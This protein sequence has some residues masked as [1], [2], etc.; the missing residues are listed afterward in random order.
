MRRD[1]L[2]NTRHI[3]AV[4]TR[5]RRLG[6]AA[7]ESSLQLIDF[8]V[9]RWT[10]PQQAA[11]RIARLLRTTYTRVVVLRTIAPNSGRN[12][13]LTKTNNQIICRL[14]K[15]SSIRVARVTE[16]RL[17]QH[18]LKQGSQTKYQVAAYLAREFPELVWWLPTQRKPW[19]KENRRMAIFD[20]IALGLV[21]VTARNRRKVNSA[22]N[23]D[24]A[25]SFRRSLD[26]AA[27]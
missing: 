22:T 5:P 6:Y 9:T 17:K 2:L 15:R 25:E 11:A 16:R 26:G 12:R 18:F 8:G 7:F 20:A 3:L 1:E 4:D 24:R 21:Y 13:P 23:E 14:A 10:S 19:E 27:K